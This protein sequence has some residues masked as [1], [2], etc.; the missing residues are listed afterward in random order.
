MEHL[1]ALVH[2]SR[3]EAALGELAQATASD[4]LDEPGWVAYVVALHRSQRQAEALDAVSRA[5]RALA[6]VGL[7]PGAALVA[8]QAEVLAA[9]A[10]A[11]AQPRL[12]A[13]GTGPALHAQRRDGV[14]RPLGRAAPTCSCSTRR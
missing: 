5:R 10:P 9:E 12:V 3:P 4:P 13:R 1:E 11:P 7:D 8:A 6:E 14:R 2:G